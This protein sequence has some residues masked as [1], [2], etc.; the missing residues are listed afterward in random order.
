MPDPKLGGWAGYEVSTARVTRT[1]DESTGVGAV[2][3]IDR[4]LGENV[5]TERV[6]WPG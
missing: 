3:R 4:L 5:L 6:G 2:S 1:S